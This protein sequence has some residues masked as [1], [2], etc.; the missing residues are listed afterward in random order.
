MLD[1]PPLRALRRL[2]L[3]EQAAEIKPPAWSLRQRLW[4]I[5]GLLVVAGAA[6]GGYLRWNRPPPPREEIRA[7]ILE[8][9]E[10]VR[11]NAPRLDI[12]EAR[13]VFNDLKARPLMTLDEVVKVHPYNEQYAELLSANENRMLVAWGLA[14]LGIAVVAS[15][16]VLA[17]TA[18]GERRTGKLPG[19]LR[20]GHRAAR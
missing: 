14:G 13:S 10:L 11:Q 8:D 6:L 1:V 18:P 17:A 12:L 3:A 16:H 19:K 15:S 7:E 9:A 20:K 5:G 2:P 4:V